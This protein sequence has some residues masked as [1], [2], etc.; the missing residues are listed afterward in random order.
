MSDLPPGAIW[1][2]RRFP[3]RGLRIWCWILAAFALAAHAL[4]LP[5]LTGPSTWWLGLA[6][7]LLLGGLIPA[8]VLRGALCRV[9]ADGTLRYGYRDRLRIA[10]PL[11]QVR[12]IRPVQAGL[13][14]GIGLEIAPELVQFADRRGPGY[15]A[16]H[17]WRR[18]LGVDLVLEF[19]LPEDGAALERL[20]DTCR[21]SRQS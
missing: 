16:L 17:T 19:L 14:R 5:L 12:A 10:V 8:H 20:R 15:A 18:D 4:F 3:A 1:Q 6:V 2:V 7:G 13:L 9:E 11:R 21:A